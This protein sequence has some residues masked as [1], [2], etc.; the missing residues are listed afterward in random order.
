[1]FW[2]KKTVIKDSLLLLIYYLSMNVAYSEVLEIRL[3]L[4][5]QI[6]NGKYL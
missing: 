3:I 4:V 1:M 2:S 5:I 6:S